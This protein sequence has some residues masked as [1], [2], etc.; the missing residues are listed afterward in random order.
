MN[1]RVTSSSHFSYSNTGELLGQY[2]NGRRLPSPIV[3]FSTAAIDVSTSRTDDVRDDTGR[4]NIH[5]PRQKLREL[6]IERIDPSTMN[7]GKK[8]TQYSEDEEGLKLHFEDGTTQEA[9]VAVAAD[10]IYSALRKMKSS[11]HDLLRYLGLVVVLGFTEGLLLES[12]NDRVQVQWVDGSTRVF[13][14]PF[15]QTRT[16]WQLS[17]P[18]ASEAEAQQIASSQRSLRLK[19]NDACARYSHGLYI[20]PLS[21]RHWSFVTTGRNHS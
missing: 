11:S 4:H 14:M 20:H 9:L 21:A 6:L 5:I 1:S 2:G 15:D 19:V 18:V 17:F 13:C 7:W 3:E 10:G 16:M 8:L 12:N